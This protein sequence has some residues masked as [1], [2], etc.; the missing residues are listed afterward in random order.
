MIVIAR[1]ILVNLW[2]I[3]PQNPI[4]YNQPVEQ[5]E[6]HLIWLILAAGKN[7]TMAAKVAW[8]MVGQLKDYSPF[9]LFRRMKHEDLA[10]KIKEAGGGCFTQKAT[11]IQ[12]ISKDIDLRTISR[13]DLVKFKGIK[14]KTASCFLLHTRPRIKMIGLDRH[15]MRHLHELDP[16][17]PE[18]PPSGMKQ[19]LKY[20]ERALQI[21]NNM[22]ISP[23][24]FDLD[25]WRL[26]STKVKK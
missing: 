23:A 3:D 25:I 21:A 5:L 17:F 8:N 12:G 19:Y 16:T 11:Y 22:S 6:H 7:G 14:Y 9:T 4:D 24:R 13:T 1:R 20:E 26:R 15:V 2:E 10:R 18:S